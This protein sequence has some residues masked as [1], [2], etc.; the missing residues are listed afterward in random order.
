M[1]NNPEVGTQYEY[2]PT[3]STWEI[4]E[5]PGNKEVKLVCVEG[6]R[7]DDTEWATV[8]DIGEWPYVDAGAR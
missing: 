3:G 7:E 6:S 4:C 5:V 1:N 8:A 2:A